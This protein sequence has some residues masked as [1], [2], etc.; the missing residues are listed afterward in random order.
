MK[1]AITSARLRGAAK[2]DSMRQD[3]ASAPTARARFIGAWGS[4]NREPLRQRLPTPEALA[5]HSAATRRSLPWRDARIWQIAAL[6]TLLGYGLVVL[7]FDQS[8]VAVALILGSA[9]LTQYIAGRIVGLASFDPLSPLITALSLS[10]LLRASDPIWL[11][12]GAMLAIGSKFVL[13]WNG[14]HVFN[15]ANFALAGLILVGAPAWISPAQWGSA[16]W[17]AFLFASLAILVLSRARRADI[18]V[19]FLAAYVAILVAR[20]L[21]L[22]DPWTI[23]M[24]Q[25]QSG[26]VLLFAFF[27]IS[28]PKTTPDTRAMRIV[29]AALVAGLAATIQFAW[30]RPEGLILALFILSPIVPLLDLVSRRRAGRMLPR[31]D[32]SRP[33]VN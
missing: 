9:L 25:M 10:I 4:I 28:D 8:P 32:W 19:A 12:L 6:S 1:L 16:T 2:V 15:P 21:Y 29:F 33:V 20:A 18:A 11:V 31:F 14:K 17:A 27:M 22:G 5:G 3:T 24:K 30:W 26:A 13:R 7:G 23:P